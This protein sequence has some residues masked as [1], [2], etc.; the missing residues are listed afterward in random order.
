M[1]QSCFATFLV[2]IKTK[3][4]GKINHKSTGESKTVSS[5]VLSQCFSSFSITLLFLRFTLQP[6]NCS[7]PLTFPHA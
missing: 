6:T 7:D 4:T 3:P 1:G 5:F 2:G